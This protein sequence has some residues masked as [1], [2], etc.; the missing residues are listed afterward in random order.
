MLNVSSG[1]VPVTME[2]PGYPVTLPSSVTFLWH[3]VG[4][5]SCNIGIYFKELSLGTYEYLLDIFPI[6]FSNATSRL[7]Y[8]RFYDADIVYFV[9]AASQLRVEL[10]FPYNEIARGVSASA[11]CRP[12]SGEVFNL[13]TCKTYNSYAHVLRIICIYSLTCLMNR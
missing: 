7:A 10:T 6:T 3:I 2:T 11:V 8:D 5:D 12:E 13:S 4:D 9:V 1:G